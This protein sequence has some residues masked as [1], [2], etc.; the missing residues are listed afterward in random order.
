MGAGMRLKS[1]KSS[2]NSEQK[3][4][5][6]ASRSLISLFLIS[7][8][9]FTQTAD[10]SCKDFLQGLLISKSKEASSQSEREERMTEKEWLGKYKDKLTDATSSPEVLKERLL[11]LER[12]L[13]KANTRQS[14][15]KTIKNWFI[16]SKSKS[17]KS[18]TDLD[19][20]TAEG[21]RY[22]LERE[23]DFFEYAKDNRED[24]NSLRSHKAKYSKGWK[25]EKNYYFL[26]EL[27]GKLVRA[28]RIDGA[29]I[30]YSPQLKVD[31]LRAAKIKKIDTTE[32]G[33]T[34]WLRGL[35][36]PK[37]LPEDATTYELLSWLQRRYIQLGVM[38]SALIR[39]AQ[40]VEKAGYTGSAAIAAFAA[41]ILVV[42]P[43]GDM[44][45]AL[46]DP[47]TSPLNQEINRWSY[48]N[49]PFQQ[50]WL[51][52]LSKKK[53]VADVEDDEMHLTA[54]LINDLTFDESGNLNPNFTDKYLKAVQSGYSGIWVAMKGT[55]SHYSRSSRADGYSLQQRLLVIVN[56]TRNIDSTIETIRSNIEF[57]EALG[58]H[59]KD[60]EHIDDLRETMV[61]LIKEIGHS[62]VMW[63]VV[64]EA[65]PEMFNVEDPYLNLRK[66]SGFLG[67]KR[68]VK[69]YRMA[70]EHAVSTY[71]K[72]IAAQNAN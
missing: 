60:K 33:F 51:N 6:F 28:Y 59:E 32:K 70:V 20:V 67:H 30:N 72:E 3:T 14:L 21:K 47:L 29:G 68:Y 9:L 48:A 62:I 36:L 25:G 43:G 54:E 41:T 56:H 52:W 44:G 49:I 37:R 66:L 64:V 26:K 10:A 23:A 19:V 7:S 69:K 58:I 34:S 71:Q 18:E 24:V 63:S 16:L 39:I 31:L 35:E 12:E 61:E 38:P 50:Q 42:G 46:V 15:F 45:R 13:A 53:K 8:L 55:M 17:G 22:N 5:N 65:Y 2:I 40:K 4:S 27:T 57:K 1:L 11:E